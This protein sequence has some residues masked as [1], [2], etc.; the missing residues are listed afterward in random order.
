MEEKIKKMKEKAK[1]ISGL[2]EMSY[3]DIEVAP[4]IPLD[5]N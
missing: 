5:K 2:I 3:E 4:P 1:E